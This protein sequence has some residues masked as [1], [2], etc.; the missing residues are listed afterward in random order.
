VV[1]VLVADTEVAAG[2]AQ[3]AGERAVVVDMAGAPAAA[4]EGT[5]ARAAEVDAPALRAAGTMA[6]RITISRG[7]SFRNSRR[8]P[9]PT[10]K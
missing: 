1:V 2:A 3:V 10:S 9:R 8:I 5:A 6:M 7:R 4:V